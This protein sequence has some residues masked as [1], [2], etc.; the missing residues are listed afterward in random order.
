MII[1]SVIYIH[2][3]YPIIHVNLKKSYLMNVYI[4]YCLT[5]FLAMDINKINYHP[6]LIKFLIKF[7]AV[8]CLI[9]EEGMLES[10]KFTAN[11][12]RSIMQELYVGGIHLASRILGKSI[13][14]FFLKKITKLKAVYYLFF[15]NCV[16][17]KKLLN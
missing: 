8:L 2:V 9:C 11:K 5:L 3:A 17:I 6:I 10:I 12:L 7:I 15:I 13:N 4:I 14:F 1:D 16:N